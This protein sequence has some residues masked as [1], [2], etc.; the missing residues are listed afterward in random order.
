MA[1][2]LWEIKIV[3]QLLLLVFLQY[4]PQYFFNKQHFCRSACLQQRSMHVLPTKD[5]MLMFLE[6]NNVANDLLHTAHSSNQR[7]HES[8]L[9]LLLNSIRTGGDLQQG[10]WQY[11]N[12][13]GDD[14]YSIHWLYI[15]LFC[16]RASNVHVSRFEKKS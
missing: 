6:G 16:N 13:K 7:S 12:T 15:C 9:V 3:N 4:K 8:F 10:H 1:S 11:E 14:L 2:I 5:I